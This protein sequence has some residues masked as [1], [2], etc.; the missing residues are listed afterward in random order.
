MRSLLRA[1]RAIRN[2]YKTPLGSATLRRYRM[3]SN[4]GGAVV[5]AV[6]A[7][8]PVA[9]ALYASRF[10]SA[11]LSARVPGLNRLPVQAQGPVMAAGVILLA[12]F[13]TKKVGFLAKHRAPSCWASA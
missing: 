12:H 5:D 4:P 3:R 10:A 7:A 1:R 8:V 11:W 9:L 6:K 2:R 13:G